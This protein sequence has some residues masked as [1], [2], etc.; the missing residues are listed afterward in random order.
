MVRMRRKK[1]TS[2][3]VGGM[4]TCAATMKDRMEVPQKVKNRTT[5]WSSNCKTEY[6]PKKYKSTNSK[7]YHVPMFTVVLQ[8][9]YG[10]NPTVH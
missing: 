4:E 8:S 6:L 1:E 9:Y 2:C 10:S 7:G 3:T 5:L